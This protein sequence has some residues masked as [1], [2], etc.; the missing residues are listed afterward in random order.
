MAEQVDA[1]G[2]AVQ[3]MFTVAN[4]LQKKKMTALQYDRDWS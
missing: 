2:S 1:D 4:Q 3:A